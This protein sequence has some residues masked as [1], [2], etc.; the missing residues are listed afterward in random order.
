M[1]TQS[2]ADLRVSRAVVSSLA[3]QGTTHPFEIRS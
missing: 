3:P 1:S 2:F